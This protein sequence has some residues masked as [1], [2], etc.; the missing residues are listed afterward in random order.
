M[1][2]FILILEALVLVGGIYMGV[3][4]GGMGLGLWGAV[5]V[6]V[7]VFV[8]RVKPGEIPTDAIMV[9]LAVIT[10][11]SAM[12]AAGGIDYLVQVAEKVIRAR[13]QSV[14]IIAPLVSLL[15][16]AAAGTGNIVFP[17]LPVIYEVAYGR[18]IRPEGAVD[19]GRRIRRRAGLQPRRCGDGRVHRPDRQRARRHRHRADP[20]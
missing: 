6:L 13:P 15:F 9:I 14:N 8:F 12:Q 2:T 18:G 3:R 20:G 10:A 7:L 16:C 19:L 1:D 4:T 11:A 5:G 17:L